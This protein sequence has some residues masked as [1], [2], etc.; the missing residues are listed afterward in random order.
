MTARKTSG[1][2][3]RGLD[4]LIR[5]EEENEKKPTEKAT[6]EKEEKS[7]KSQSSK[8]IS[9]KEKAVEDVLKE[10]HNNPRISLWSARSAAVLRFLKKTKPEFS[11]SKEASALIEAAVEQKYPEIWEI[12]NGKNLK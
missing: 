8:S 1:A 4:A 7:K 9:K 6:A 2:L 11:I 12:F 3:G 10:V 5:S